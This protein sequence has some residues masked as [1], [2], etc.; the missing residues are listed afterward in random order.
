M[1]TA[2][3]A[4]IFGVTPALKK[5]GKQL[6]NAL[7]IDP[8]QGKNM[9]FADEETAYQYFIKNVG[10]DNY[11][12]LLK[13]AL[14]EQP[15][16]QILIGFSV[17]ATTLWRYAGT[18]YD[19]GP[20]NVKKIIGFYGGQIRQ[21]LDLIPKVPVELIF[22]QSEIHFSVS[23]LIEGLPENEHLSVSRCDYLHGFMNERSTNYHPEAYQ[24]Y[25]DKL[26][27]NLF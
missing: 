5:L 6:N 13:S 2:L 8:Y 16:I 7:I 18:C 25:L 11:L 1:S 27:N 26:M 21:Y 15:N 23:K 4:D 3:V 20:I 22:P 24:Y 14:K 10:L 9:G 19:I 12:A 17:G